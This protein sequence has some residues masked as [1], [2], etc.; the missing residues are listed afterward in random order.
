M[1]LSKQERIGAMIILA[2]VILALGAFLLI[3]PKIEAIGSTRETLTQK[4]KE[5]NDAKTKQSKK[6]PL[7]DQILDAYQ[8]GEHL[9][10]MFFPELATYEADDAFREFLLQCKSNIVVEELDVEEP[11]VGTLGVSFYTPKN[12]E[13]ALKTYAT[14]GMEPT[15]EESRLAARR[16]AME[17][18]LGTPMSIGAS[19]VSFTVSALTNDDLIKFCDE[20]NDYV[21]TENGTSSRK[22][23]MIDGLALE[24]RDVTKF[25]DAL[26]E[27]SISEMESGA[28]LDALR[29]LSGKDIS[30]GN[31]GAGGYDETGE[32]N[33][34]PSAEVYLYKLSDAITFYSIERM[35]NPTAQLDAQDNM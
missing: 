29:Q 20:I 12:V 25:Y 1:K 23:V 32:S 6:D 16:V 30:G 7:R 13:Y 33:E 14:Q 9:A 22:A 10:D 15:E 35:Q 18:A 4:Q 31:N 2:I 3:K 21:K 5:L 24:Y 28:G 19:R 17:N 34:R 11:G 26:S 27:R 8:E